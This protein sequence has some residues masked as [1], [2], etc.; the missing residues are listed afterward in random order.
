MLFRAPLFYNNGNKPISQDLFLVYYQTFIKKINSGREQNSFNQD[1]VVQRSVG[2]TK[3]LLEI[4]NVI[5]I[6][7]YKDI[8]LV[9]LLL[10]C[11][12]N[13]EYK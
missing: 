2:I 1:P 13:F 7:L 4:E 5:K 11:T 6:I 8:D 12:L 10:F 9:W 3:W